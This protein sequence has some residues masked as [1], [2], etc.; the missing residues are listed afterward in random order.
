[1]VY[2]VGIFPEIL[3]LK[4]SKCRNIIQK[5]INR[6]YLNMWLKWSKF[7]KAVKTVKIQAKDHKRNRIVISWEW[8]RVGLNYMRSFDEDGTSETNMEALL[9]SI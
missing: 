4:G 5:V 6:N 9:E 2:L 3:P 7:I 1:M 8:D